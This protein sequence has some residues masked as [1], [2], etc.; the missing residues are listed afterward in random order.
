MKSCFVGCFLCEEAKQLEI[1]GCRSLAA[2]AKNIWGETRPKGGTKYVPEKR[3]HTP[4][5]VEALDWLPWG[6]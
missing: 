1:I 6:V 5:R 2:G 4:T 3:V